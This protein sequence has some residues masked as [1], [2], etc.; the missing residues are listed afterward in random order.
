MNNPSARFAYNITQK[1][2]R[3]ISCEVGTFN[4]FPQNGESESDVFAEMR[5]VTFSYCEVNLSHSKAILERKKLFMT[6]N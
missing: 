3:Q 4:V 1:L 6:R 5:L 2:C